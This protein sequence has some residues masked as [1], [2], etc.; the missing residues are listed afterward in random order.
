MPL[1]ILPK[2]YTFMDNEIVARKPRRMSVAEFDVTY[3]PYPGWK[4]VFKDG[5]AHHV[6]KSYV[7]GGEI[8]PIEWQSILIR[9]LD[10]K[11]TRLYNKKL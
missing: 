8:D 2:G 7:E 4:F 5:M 9:G 10:G 1:Q 6:P 3:T 11:V